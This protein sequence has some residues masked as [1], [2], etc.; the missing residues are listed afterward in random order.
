MSCGLLGNSPTVQH[1]HGLEV[2]AALEQ[3]ARGAVC[4]ENTPTD[5]QL[6]Q[7]GSRARQVLQGCVRHL[8]SQT[9]FTS[10]KILHEVVLETLHSHSTQTRRTLAQP[11]MMSLDRALQ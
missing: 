2:S 3:D 4:Q 8:V 6:F 7:A 1:S 10:S 11:A 9:R 5:V